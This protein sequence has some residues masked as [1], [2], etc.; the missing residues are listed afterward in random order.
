MTQPKAG[1]YIMAGQRIMDGSFDQQQEAEEFLH[2]MC[3]DYATPEL[4]AQ[5]LAHFDGKV[6]DLV[7]DENGEVINGHLARERMKA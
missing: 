3:G 2:Q 6:L 7:K 5:F 4:L 1:Y